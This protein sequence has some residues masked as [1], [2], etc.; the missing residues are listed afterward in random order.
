M[1]QLPTTDETKNCEVNNP[2]IISK[3]NEFA[4]PGDLVATQKKFIILLEI[5]LLMKI[6]QI[7]EKVLLER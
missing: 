6:M 4:V 2:T 3:A 5:I 1:I 7:Q